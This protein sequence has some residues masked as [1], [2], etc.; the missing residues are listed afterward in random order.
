MRLL[1]RVTGKVEQRGKS[2][3]KGGKRGR[4]SKGDQD[5]FSRLR[6]DGKRD[7]HA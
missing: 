1:G 7:A 6:A 2:R 5:A 4:G 3:R